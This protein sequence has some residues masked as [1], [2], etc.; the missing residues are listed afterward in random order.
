MKKTSRRFLFQKHLLFTLML[1]LL[2]ALVGCESVDKDDALVSLK[3]IRFEYHE[4]TNMTTIYCDVD[5]VNNTIYNLDS[6]GLNL[7]TYSSGIMISNK[8]VEYNLNVKHGE[9]SSA[10]A[11]FTQE[12]EIDRV[13]LVSWNPNFEPLWKTYINTLVILGLLLLAGIAYWVYQMFF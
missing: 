8:D 4:N 1:L 5:I 3:N 12:G 11:T 6:F 2:F 13:G 7:S 10:T 9:S